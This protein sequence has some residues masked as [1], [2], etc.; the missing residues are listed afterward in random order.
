M[1]EHKKSN[2]LFSANKP[3]QNLVLLFQPSDKSLSVISLESVH[4]S[5][6]SVASVLSLLRSA[7]A[8]FVLRT[9]A[10]SPPGPTPELQG[11]VIEILT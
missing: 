3:G 7:K 10:Q 11:V 5:T 8:F 4:S 2:H 9:M 1:E 6:Y